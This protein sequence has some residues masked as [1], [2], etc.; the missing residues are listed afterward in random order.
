MHAQPWIVS[1]GE[2]LL[3]PGRELF[4]RITRPLIGNAVQATGQRIALLPQQ[5]EEQFVL[6]LEVTIK[7]PGGQA[8]PLQDRDHRNGAAMGLGQTG[9]CS[10]DD[11]I[12]II[13]RRCIGLHDRRL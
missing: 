8:G 12:T 6:R 5:R 4:D 11:A 13:G 2:H 3:D 10:I 9:V 7:R 1:Q